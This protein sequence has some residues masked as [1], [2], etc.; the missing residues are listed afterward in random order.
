M[1]TGAG[2]GAGIATGAGAGAPYETTLPSTMAPPRT[3]ARTKVRMTF[4]LFRPYL[5]SSASRTIP[6]QC[7]CLKMCSTSSLKLAQLSVCVALHDLIV[8]L[9]KPFLDSPSWDAYSFLPSSVTKAI[10][11]WLHLTLES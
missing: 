11:R 6:P 9:L 4:M 7:L 8:S 3:R 1:A 10:K 5:P 2:A